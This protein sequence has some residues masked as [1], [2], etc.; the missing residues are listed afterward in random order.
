M[1]TLW[2]FL[3][4]SAL[5]IALRVLGGLGMGWVTYQGFQTAFNSMKDFFIAHY[6]G[7]PLT[8]AQLFGLAGIPEAFSMILGA[9]AMRI[10]YISL[11]ATLSKL[12]A[13]S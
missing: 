12:P 6:S 7:L 3:L 10:A 2:T 8:I 9:S 5:P 13:S 4:N 11:T 1:A